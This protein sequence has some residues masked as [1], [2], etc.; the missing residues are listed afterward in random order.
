MPRRTPTGGRPPLRVV[1]NDSVD[2]HFTVHVGQRLQELRRHAGL[3]Q[4]RAAVGAGLTRNTLMTLERA[5]HPD[6]RLSTLLKLMMLYNLG[7]IEELLGA[8]PSARLMENLARA[9][10]VDPAGRGSL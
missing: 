4:E 10:P 8:T 1:Q 3:T 7:S 6:P 5:A 9:L 2:A